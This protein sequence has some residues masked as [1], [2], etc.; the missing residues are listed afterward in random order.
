ML[1][2]SNRGEKGH[3]IVDQSGESWS[4]Y[5]NNWN[6][7]FVYTRLNIRLYNIMTNHFYL[8]SKARNQS[9]KRSETSKTEWFW[10]CDEWSEHK[11]SICGFVCT[12]SNADEAFDYSRMMESRI[13]AQW[14]KEPKWCHRCLRHTEMF[15]QL[16]R[17]LDRGC[18]PSESQWELRCFRFDSRYI[19]MY[20]GLFH[21][22]SQPYKACCG[23]KAKPIIILYNY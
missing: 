12:F 1:L 15:K 20:L 4:D 8:H 3:L 17:I 7:I 10:I 11:Q 14:R 5:C 13:I 19:K 16:K 9:I 21:F 2:K 18:K 22:K 6:S 23:H